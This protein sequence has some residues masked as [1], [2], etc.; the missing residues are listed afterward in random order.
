MF[1][2]QDG[3]TL[4]DLG[5][6]LANII[7]IG[8]IFEI[9]FET[10]KARVII[11]DLTTD[12][13][14]WINSNS[15]A[16]NSW[17]P[18]EIDEQV[19]ILSVSGEL[20]QGVILPSLYKNNAPENSGNIQSTTFKDGSKITFDHSSGNLDLNIKGNATIIVGGNA[21]IESSSILLKGNIDLGESGGKPLARIGDEIEITSGSSAGKW[22]IISGSSKVKA[23]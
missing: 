17:N 6:R 1:D 11:G 3:F 5:R 15:G 20:N 8:T 23:A 13:L 7:R 4:N 10:A 9:D 2:E 16:N 12:W 19:I 21:L 18:P 14:P 22:P